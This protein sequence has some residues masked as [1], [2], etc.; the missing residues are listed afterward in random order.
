MKVNHP[1]KFYA[2]CQWKRFN[3]RRIERTIFEI[4]FGDRPVI[5]PYAWIFK[6]PVEPVVSQFGPMT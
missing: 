6:I 2:D 1:I 4:D 5:Y 3:D